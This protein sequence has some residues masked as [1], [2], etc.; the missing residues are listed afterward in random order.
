VGNDYSWREYM[1]YNYSKG[2]AF[3][4]EYDGHWSLIAGEAWYP[5]LAEVKDFSNTAESAG[6]EYLLFNKYAPRITALI[7]EFDWDV[8]EERVRV[9]ELINPP[10]ILVKEQNTRNRA[11]VDYYLG[12][13][14][15]PKEIAEAFKIELSKFPEK[16]GE[17]ANQPSK[18]KERWPKVVTLSGVFAILV[19]LIQAVILFMKPEE[20]LLKSHFVL[21][22]QVSAA[23]TDSVLKTMQPVS[24]NLGAPAGASIDTIKTKSKADSINKAGMDSIAQLNA[25]LNSTAYD[26]GNFELKPIRSKS[27]EVTNGPA[28]LD[29]QISSPVDNNWFEADLELVS[30]K[31]NQTWNVGKQIEYYHGYDDGDSWSEGSVDEGV[32]LSGI[33][34]G[35]YHLNIYAY[36]G[37]KY[38]NTLDVIVTENVTLWRNLFVTL[39]VLCLYPAFCWYMMRRTEI[40]RWTYSDY[41]PYQKSE[42]D[43]DE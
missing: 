10:Y 41:S 5:E 2:Y 35:R 18:W 3:L 40:R 39:L 15:E 21:E 8:Y 17:G 12:Y 38:N 33:P 1:L 31:D 36:G 34:P 7:G 19:V 16:V 43:D 29:F 27:F 23:K 42:E 26:N 25:A 37:H 32:L 14:I 6:V 30:E 24:S 22:P 11:I 4:A 13:Y 20:E 9:S 28:P